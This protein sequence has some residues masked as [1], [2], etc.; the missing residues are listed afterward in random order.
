MLLS[1]SNLETLRQEQENGPQESKLDRIIAYIN[2]QSEQFPYN[3]L[4]NSQTNVSIPESCKSDDKYS[5]AISAS[6]SDIIRRKCAQPTVDSPVSQMK[7]MKKRLYTQSS[8]NHGH[9]R[10][11]QSSKEEHAGATT[12]PISKSNGFHLLQ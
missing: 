10:V 9:K 3:G 4:P 12:L 2:D 7:E 1:K 5:Y 6:I 8:S 11:K